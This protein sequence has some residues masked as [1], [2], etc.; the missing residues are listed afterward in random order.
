MT[1]LILF[2]TMFPLILFDR[3]LAMVV[4][5][6]VSLVDILKIPTDCLHAID[7]TLNDY[8]KAK[9]EEVDKAGL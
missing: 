3:A 1:K 9:Q 2:C 5:N 6:I 4:R 7:E 8:E